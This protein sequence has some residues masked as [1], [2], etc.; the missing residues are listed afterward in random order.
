MIEVAEASAG[1]P[2][3]LAIALAVIA[4][5]S[6]AAVALAPALVERIRQRGT[7]KDE[8]PAPSAAPSPA[9]DLALGMVEQALR[10]A[11]QQ[12]DEAE[13]R[14]ERMERERDQARAQ[15]ARYRAGNRG[16]DA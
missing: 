6:T 4:L 9:A 3:W 5:A 16:T 14:A 8:P 7:N 10:D 2:P 11:W 1:G 13:A 12:R 15:L